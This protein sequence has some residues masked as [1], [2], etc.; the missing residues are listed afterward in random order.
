MIVAFGGKAG[1]GKD[2]AARC[3][4]ERGFKKCSF[5]AP[6]K[7]ITA[8]FLSMQVADLEKF[9]NK[10]FGD[11]LRL[12]PFMLHH[13]I[14]CLETAI[15]LTEKQQELIILFGLGKKLSSIRQCLQFIGTDLVREIVHDNT[16]IS[17]ALMD[18]PELAVFT[19]VRFPNELAALHK[20]NAKSI[21]VQ[22]NHAEITENQ[23][24]TEN[25]LTKDNFLRYINNTKDI[26]NLHKEVLSICKLER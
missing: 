23:H 10:Q 1:S 3:L 13:L 9:K 19:D 26:K 17:L 8:A 7:E 25:L 16:W 21:Y 12:D 4:I 5:A 18:L 11:Y 22:R 15:P 14:E 6:L 24:I 20:L 2:T